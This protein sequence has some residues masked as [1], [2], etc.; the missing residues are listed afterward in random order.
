M[1]KGIRSQVPQE[2]FWANFE[3]LLL[4]GGHGAVQKCFH[5]HRP[6][7]LVIVFK[8]VWYRNLNVSK[9]IPF[10]KPRVEH[11]VEIDFSYYVHQ[12][13]H[14]KQWNSDAA[15]EMG[16]ARTCKRDRPD[17]ICSAPSNGHEQ[18]E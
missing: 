3:K 13:L 16:V 11:L 8:S 6:G 4:K 14:P 15:L 10:F 1:G 17:D 12:D 9:M 18:V 2:A 5:L 7:S